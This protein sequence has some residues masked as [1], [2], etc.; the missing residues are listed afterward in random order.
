MKKVLISLSLVVI[1]C[2]LLAS[3]SEERRK[4]FEN[5]FGNTSDIQSS[6]VDTVYVL[7]E[8]DKTDKKYYLISIEK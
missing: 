3:C 8:L 7:N 4:N 1:S 2:L 6:N 5:N